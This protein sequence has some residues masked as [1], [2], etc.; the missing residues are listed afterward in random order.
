MDIYEFLIGQREEFP[1]F[2]ANWTTPSDSITY[3][4]FNLVY[5]SLINQNLGAL[6]LE[7][8]LNTSEK[9]STSS[10]KCAYSNHKTKLQTKQF[11]DT[12]LDSL[13]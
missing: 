7:I 9:R 3:L 1:E 2:K 10:N 8:Y 4:L 11:P 5:F 6:D 13:I 12:K